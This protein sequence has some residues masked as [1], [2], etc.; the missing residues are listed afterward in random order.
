MK[1]W[2]EYRLRRGLFPKTPQTFVDRVR[3]ALPVQRAEQ[4][5]VRTEEPSGQKLRSAAEPSEEAVPFDAELLGQEKHR[6]RFWPALGM[7]V[8]TIVAVAC[9]LLVI[10]RVP[11]ERKKS[12][13]EMEDFPLAS[14]PVSEPAAESPGPGDPDA[15]GPVPAAP[16]EQTVV[17]TW[18]L[19]KIDYNGLLISASAFRAEQMKLTFS[20]DGTVTETERYLSSGETGAYT[21]DGHTVTFSGGSLYLADGETA[22]YDPEADTLTMHREKDGD[23]KL[24]FRRE[25]PKE[26]EKRTAIG[27]WSYASGVD[28]AQRLTIRSDGTA[29]MR[30]ESNLGAVD[31]SLTY[32]EEDGALI[33][34][35]ELLSR[36][37]ARYD[38]ETDTLTVTI[39]MESAVYK[40]AIPELKGKWTLTEIETNGTKMSPAQLGAIFMAYLEFT[41]DGDLTA[42]I[43]FNDEVDREEYRYFVNGTSIDIKTSDDTIRRDAIV[44]D[45]VTDTL[46]MNVE[47]SHSSDFVVIG[48]LIF[49]RTPD[50]E[51]PEIKP[52]LVGKWTVTEVQMNGETVDPSMFGEKGGM[53]LELN[54]DGSAMLTG[55]NDVDG[56]EQ[57]GQYTVTENTVVITDENGDPLTLTYDPATD[58]LFAEHIYSDYNLTL[59]LRFAHT[60]D[61][62]IPE[63]PSEELTELKRLYPEYFGLDTTNG[64]KVYVWQMS[65]ESYSCALVSG[66]EE[67]TDAE[68]CKLS[69]ISIERMLLIL[70]TYDVPAEQIEIIPFRN[71]LSSYWYEIDE[72]YTQRLIWLLNGTPDPAPYLSE[73]PETGETVYEIDDPEHI[74]NVLTDVAVFDVNGDGR[75][76]SCRLS[77]GPTSGLFT[78]VFHVYRNG[79]LVYLNTFN[80]EFGTLSFVRKNGALLLKSVPQNSTEERFYAVSI[81][82][83]AIVLTDE[84]T[85]ETVSYWGTADP[86]WN[87]AVVKTP[88]ERLE[89]LWCAMSAE[90][91]QDGLLKIGFYQDEKRGVR[92]A[93]FY[94]SGILYDGYTYTREEQES[95]RQDCSKS[96]LFTFANENGHERK[97]ILYIRD[98]NEDEIDE[99]RTPWKDDSEQHTFDTF[100][101]LTP[102]TAEELPM[103]QDKYIFAGEGRVHYLDLVDLNGDGEPVRVSVY[104]YTP[105]NVVTGEEGESELTVQIGACEWKINEKLVMD[106]GIYI[107]LDPND[108]HGNLLLS[109]TRADGTVVTYELHLEKEEP[110]FGQNMDS[111][112]LVCGHVAEGYCNMYAMSTDIYLCETAPLGGVDGERKI[113]GEALVPESDWWTVRRMMY[114]SE[115]DRDWLVQH[116]Q[117]LRLIR[118]LPCEIDGESAVLEAGTYL[119]LSRYHESLDRIEFLTEDNRTVL[120]RPQAGLLLDGTAPYTVDGVPLA[121]YF[122]NARQG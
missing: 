4:E 23:A 5:R 53:W 39:G 42:T 120:V 71:P 73:L 10:I 89:G 3:S 41:K 51:I 34:R 78:V 30:T 82:N 79:K 7:T 16:T 52:D 49:S 21:F 44:Y 96:Y 121:D 48:T 99:D 61:A 14:V 111:F 86:Q 114:S 106:S 72:A 50:A 25:Q 107:D 85:G 31:T 66:A 13:K 15:T 64:L 33:F 26:P 115:K 80:M 40:R 105:V 84:Q 8:L 58:T 47:D 54:P 6:L 81:E 35:G 101:K 122:D 108:G 22:V 113:S 74:L 77:F 17:G 92:C 24:V 83:G 88:E 102:I 45:A 69:G 9:L 36:M 67:K 87:M 56:I 11:G 117:L 38:A 20:A 76:E 70:S 65:G 43:R 104:G 1:K 94:E 2:F 112:K 18:E 46:R 75:L 62:E 100:L 55:L 110:A 32:T 68:I 59:G 90:E 57:G 63:L 93:S 28:Y 118:D 91:G 37:S 95:D 116:G 27:T 109:T 103:K 19:W 98:H 12:P 97:L 119:Y 60:P 29:T